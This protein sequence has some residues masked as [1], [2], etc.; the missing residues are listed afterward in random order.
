MTS[1]KTFAGFIRSQPRWRFVAVAIILVLGIFW[2][3]RGSKSAANLPTFTARRGPLDISVME[4][5]S[6]KALES[7]EVKCEVRVGYQGTKILRIVPEGYLVTDEDVRTNRVLCELDSS[8][9][10]NRLVQQEIQ[11]QSALASL[12]DA[13][14]NYQIQLGQNNS[15]VK[16]AQQKARFARMDFEKYLGDDVA[17]K[18][19]AQVGLDKLF[20]TVSSNNIA[21]AALAAVPDAGGL[22]KAS[23]DKAVAQPIGEVASAKLVSAV[24]GETNSASADSPDDPAASSEAEN[25]KP[26][27]EIPDIILDFSKYATLDALG[28]GQAK[29]KLRTLDDTLQTAQKDLGQA[30]T[31]LDGTKRLF[32]KGFVAKTEITRDEISYSSAVL[33]VKSSETDRALF[34]SYE[35]PRTAEENLS[36]FAEAVRLLDKADH[37]A[38]SKLAQAR[39]KLNSA[40]GQYQVQWRQRKD[41]QEQLDKC[42]LTAKK[43]GLVVYGGG[44]DNNY[45]NQEPIREGATVRERQTIITIPDLRCMSVNV[46]IHES[47]IKKIKVGQKVRITVDAYPD[48]RLTGEVTVVGLLPDSQNRWLN[49]DLKVYLTTVTIAGTNTWLKPGMSAKVEIL[50]D[51]LDDVVYVPVQSIVA[52]NGRQYCFVSGGFN[53]PERREVQIGQFN[54]EFIEV[55]KGL[56]EG[57]RVLLNPPEIPDSESAPPE[58][59]PVQPE[60][61]PSTTVAGGAAKP[62]KS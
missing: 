1:N 12:A 14:Q 22:R 4:G 29:Q 55:Q 40:R 21:A 56:K 57:E 35:F 39:A 17:D 6:L 24:L 61:Q 33:K 15:D 11:F 52:G 27:M 9:L 7:Q 16:A 34:L 59:K 38:I 45:G 28:D 3:S 46:K 23:P 50:V 36:K 43:S 42:V 20:L 49:P 10:Q 5:G 41:L 31:T 58:S 25:G 32:D 54:D 8:D 19:I 2:F 51:H 13:E 47:Y 60:S 26:L 44:D 48:Q 37:E 18:V 53:K 30:S 62:A